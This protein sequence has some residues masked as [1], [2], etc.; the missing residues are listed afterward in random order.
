MRLEKIIGGSTHASLTS[1]SRGMR[2][3]DVQVDLAR[4]LLQ[5]VRASKSE[6]DALHTLLARIEERNIDHD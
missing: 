3:S 1:T 2:A 4:R 5:R 6:V